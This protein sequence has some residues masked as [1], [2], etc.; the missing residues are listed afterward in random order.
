MDRAIYESASAFTTVPD[1]DG[2]EIKTEVFRIKRSVLQGDIMSPVFFI[3]TLEHILRHHDNARGKGVPLDTT[4]V[5]TL[6]YADEL[7][8]TDNGDADG[9]A[10][11]T[12]RATEIAA[13]SRVRADMEVKIKKTKVLHVRPQDPV[14]DTTNSE[15]LR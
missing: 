3:L 7:A 5:H 15:S 2:K 13:G 4:R 12:Q 1:A 8:L 14:T 10:R 6:G 11:A 9:V